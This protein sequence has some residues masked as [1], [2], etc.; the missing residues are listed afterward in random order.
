[1]T[2]KRSTFR[3]F[4]R[5]ARY[6]GIAIVALFFVWFLLGFLPGVPSIFEVFPLG[7]LRIPAAIVIAGLVLAA[8]GYEEL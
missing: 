2:E 8:F 5:L 7:E 3:K 6:V 4:K 1:M